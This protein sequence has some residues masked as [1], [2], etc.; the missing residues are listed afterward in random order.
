VPKLGKVTLY[1]ILFNFLSHI[2]NA[3]FLSKSERKLIS[4]CLIGLLVCNYCDAALIKL[5]PFLCQRK[6]EVISILKLTGSCGNT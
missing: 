5:G 6:N 1:I 2:S 3:V 4:V